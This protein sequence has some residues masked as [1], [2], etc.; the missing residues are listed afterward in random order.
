MMSV[1]AEERPQTVQEVLDVW[2]GKRRRPNSVTP[3]AREPG[4]TPY[5]ILIAGSSAD[6]ISTALQT[7]R[8]SNHVS[9][10]KGRNTGPGDVPQVNIEE[11]ANLDISSHERMLIHS[12]P[13]REQLNSVQTRLQEDA[14]GLVLLIDNARE[15]ALDDLD[16]FLDRF[17]DFIKSTGVVIGITRSELSKGPNIHDCHR[18]LAKSRETG[19]IAPPIM[20]VTPGNHRELRKL[21]LSLLFH[22]NP[23]L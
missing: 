19:K 16:F 17:D 1:T 15:N 7:I 20:E 22:L 12:V 5:K 14:I 8:D 11:S 13:G 21:L 9:G 10:T 23:T 6:C 2:A 3:L 18:H 4:K